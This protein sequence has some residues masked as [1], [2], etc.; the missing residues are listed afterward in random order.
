MKRDSKSITFNSSSV[1]PCK[2]DTMPSV[3][4]RQALPSKGEGGVGQFS[5]GK[6][7]DFRAT[8]FHRLAD[9]NCRNVDLLT[10]LSE[11][12]VIIVFLD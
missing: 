2:S 10:D 6:F 7:Q 11:V 1:S 5:Q 9:S 4:V 3:Y 12:I 8:G